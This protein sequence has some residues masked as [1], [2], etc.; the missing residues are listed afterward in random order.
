MFSD[1]VAFDNRKNFRFPVKTEPSRPLATN[2][3]LVSLTI[4][5]TSLLQTDILLSNVI[6]VPQHYRVPWSSDHHGDSNR[7][8]GTI[9]GYKATFGTERCISVGQHNGS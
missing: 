1:I 3:V 5:N 9:K 6:I 2:V 4:L 8:E 7:H